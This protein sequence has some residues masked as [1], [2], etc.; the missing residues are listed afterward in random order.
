MNRALKRSLDKNN[1]LITRIARKLTIAHLKE[2]EI[3]FTVV[4][5][6]IISTRQKD[7]ER[8]YNNMM[9]RAVGEF[10]NSGGNVVA[11][12]KIYNLK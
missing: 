5:D 2:Y 8:V 10:T 11:L 3:D 12:K 4:G 6:T 1:K 9:F 7:V